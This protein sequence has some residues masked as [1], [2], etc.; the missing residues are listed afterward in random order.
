MAVSLHRLQV[1]FYADAVHIDYISIEILFF[2][3][4][5]AN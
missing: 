3:V 5:R 2:Q 4:Y 1:V